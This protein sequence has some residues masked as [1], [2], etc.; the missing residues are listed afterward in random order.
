MNIGR[1][2]GDF[3]YE[4][5]LAAMGKMLLLLEIGWLTRS[6]PF[7]C[8]PLSAPVA[9]AGNPPLGEKEERST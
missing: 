5:H 3:G 2:Y 6:L 7:P 1:E 9:V 8:F 4:E